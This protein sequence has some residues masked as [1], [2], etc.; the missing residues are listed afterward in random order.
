MTEIIK[1]RNLNAHI[2]T[3]YEQELVSLRDKTLEMA[4]IVESHYTKA[5][6]ALNMQDTKAAEEISKNDYIVNKMEIEI[7]E[8][9][10]TLIDTQSPVASDLRKILVILKINNDLERVGDEAEKIARNTLEMDLNKIQKNFLNSLYHLGVESKKSINKA[11]DAYA[12]Q[13]VDSAM[14]VIKTDKYID[15]E[16][17]SCMRQLMSFMMQ[18]PKAIKNILDIT[19]IA[20]GIER[21]GDHAVNIAQHTI[22]LVIGKDIRHTSSEQVLEEI[23]NNTSYKY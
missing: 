9:C 11:I 7:D 1:D 22:Q 15:D 3:A 19:N 12:R 13:S 14:D 8:A 18:D 21:V 16:F 17:E 5:I 4:G 23:R 10:H 6:D 2:S 20:K